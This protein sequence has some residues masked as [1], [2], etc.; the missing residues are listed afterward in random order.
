MKEDEYNDTDSNENTGQSSVGIAPI[1]AY[2]KSQGLY[3]GVS[4]EG[5]RIFVR[6][7]I[8]S[9]TY[10]FTVGRDVT[11]YDILS[12]KVPTPPEAEDLYA[13]LHCVEFT[14][15]MSCLPRPPEI[16]RKD[17]ANAWYYDRSTLGDGPPSKSD[18]FNFLSTLS[19]KDLEACET[20]ETQFKKFMYGG[21]S[22]QRLLPNSESRTGRTG[23]ERRTL[24]LMLPEVGSLRL[25]FVSKLSDGESAVSNKSSTLRARQNDPTSRAQNIEGDLVTVE[26]EEVTLDSALYTEK[27]AA[28]TIGQ[29]RTGNVQ[30]SQNHSIALTDLTILS[31]DPLVPIKFN[32]VD[33]AEHLRVISM[34]D[35]A[36]TSL[37]FLANNFREAELLL[38]GLKLLLERETARL[39]VRGGLPISALGGRVLEGAMSPT[40]ARGFRDTP[41]SASI[42]ASVVPPKKNRRNNRNSKS[43]G[44][45]SSDVEDIE[46]GGSGD[47]EKP[48]AKFLPEGRKSWGRVPGRD[49]MRGQA[50]STKGNQRKDHNGEQGVPQ[51]IHGQ[52]LAKDIAKKVRLPLP[53]PLC[54]VLLLD[55]TSP[56]IAR[57]EKDRGDINFEHT[58]WTFPPATPRELERHASEHS[59]IATGSM[60]GAH[61][62]TAFDRIRNGNWV[63]LSE[64]QIVDEDDREKLAITVSERMPRRGFSIKVRIL[65]RA[66][67]DNACDATVIGEIRPVGKD[68]SNQAA[69]HKAFHLVLN[70]I[71]SRYGE[72]PGGI[73]AGFLSVIDTMGDSASDELGRGSLNRPYH[74]MEEKKFDA[75]NPKQQRGTRKDS[76]LVS[77]ED[78]LKT[79]RESPEVEAVERPSTPSLQHQ[80]PEPDPSKRISAKAK[81]AP[82][83]NEFAPVPELDDEDML[84]PKEPVL[85]EVKPLPKIRL[86]LMP[87]PREE[88]E[89]NDSSAY[90]PVDK[91]KKKKKNSS[92]KRRPSSSWRKS[93]RQKSSTKK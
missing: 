56:V 76:G 27:E 5:S 75:P 70:E 84:E 63:R 67:K 62:T 26:S 22:V 20:F 47:E 92:S 21:V 71:K 25:G 24:W 40:A 46:D 81:P 91:S 43:S 35:V 66:V 88:D 80:I 32:P 6:N 12:G 51:Y 30:L 44:Y 54:R 90:S 16:L 10:K 14:H 2:A 8:N 74:P 73:M 78:M 86:S 55:S 45:S 93:G 33:K 3:V 83:A 18:P 89:D 68:M 64:T 17:S 65:L 50:A 77:F 28:S 58:L 9:R 79:G 11:A 1:V 41:S 39:G 48:L 59:L 7:D 61:R 57:W 42:S 38:C 13:A 69:V 19:P 53:L 23:R 34:Q 49:Y 72:E 60:C 37:L 15:E 82:H 52:V 87:S 85:I 4:L 36:G 29:I 31:H